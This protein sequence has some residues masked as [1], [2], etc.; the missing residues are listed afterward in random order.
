MRINHIS[1]LQPTSYPQFKSSSS[2]YMLANKKEMGT[3]TWFFREDVNWKDFIKYQL[4]HFKDKNKVN[5][6][7]FGASDGSEAYTYIMSLMEFSDNKNTDKFY[8]IKSYDINEKIVK[9]TT[10]G[11][12]NITL[13][14]EEAMC[15]MNIKP[16]KY[17]ERPET[18][19]YS[20]VP[21]QLFVAKPVLQKKVNFNQGDMF[22]LLPKIKDDSNTI[23]LCRNCLGYFTEEFD[24]FIEQASEVL[25]KG[26]LL[27]V[28]NLERG[29]KAFE[30]SFKIHQ[31]HEIMKNVFVKL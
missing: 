1:Q 9:N 25:K 16:K 2:C 18:R 30:N 21:N 13:E 12:I 17:F 14:D 28:G 23:L 19:P 6:V 10:Q 20:Y 3:F 7:Q 29:E 5:I 24:S 11:L 22:K 8:P 26:S 31:F 4:E 27:V 15:K